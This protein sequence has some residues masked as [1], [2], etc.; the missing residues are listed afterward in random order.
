L[1]LGSAEIATNFNDFSPTI[2]FKHVFEKMAPAFRA[3]RVEKGLRERIMWRDFS[4]AFRDLWRIPGDSGGSYRPDLHYMRGPG[5][6]WHA[7]YG[8]LNAKTSSSAAPSRA[9]L[10]NIAERRA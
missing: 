4:R 1:E 8:S 7:K 10:H 2:R 5:P 9:S 3:G 6:K